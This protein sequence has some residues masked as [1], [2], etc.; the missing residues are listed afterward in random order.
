MTKLY[1]KCRFESIEAVFRNPN[2]GWKIIKTQRVFGKA[3][4]LCK[5]CNKVFEAKRPDNLFC[6]AE[7]KN[8]FNV[9]KSRDKD[10]KAALKLMP[11]GSF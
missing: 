10:K 2:A 6:S 7:C 11:E 8:R 5:H 4:R 1:P 9:Y 3:L